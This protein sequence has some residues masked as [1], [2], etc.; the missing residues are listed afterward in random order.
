[1]AE[2]AKTTSR[3]WQISAQ[4]S[5]VIFLHANIRHNIIIISANLTARMRNYTGNTRVTRTLHSQ[6]KKR[7]IN[8]TIQYSIGLRIRNLSLLL[9]IFLR[10]R[11]FFLFCIY[12]WIR[13]VFL[14]GSCCGYGMFSCSH[15]DCT[16][17]QK[18]FFKFAMLIKLGH[19]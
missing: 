12:L 17:S 19:F 3:S 8:N 2:E 4:I 13:T 9:C 16:L 6:S 11:K 5:E 7:H 18:R 1:M 14:F 15:T 10:I